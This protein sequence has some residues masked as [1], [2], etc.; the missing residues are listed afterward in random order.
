MHTE[1]DTKAYVFMNQSTTT[2]NDRVKLTHIFKSG[3]DRGSVLLD[4]TD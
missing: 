3:Q 4:I 1:N 2:T